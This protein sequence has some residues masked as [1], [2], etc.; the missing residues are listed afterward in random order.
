MAFVDLLYSYF[1]NKCECV[2]KTDSKRGLPWPKFHNFLRFS[3]SFM[4]CIYSSFPPPLC[5]FLS[6]PFVCACVRVCSPPFRSHICLVL[7]SILSVR[8]LP[9]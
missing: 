3:P 4:W 6:I 7:F 5:F 2:L 8:V 1:Y 9:S